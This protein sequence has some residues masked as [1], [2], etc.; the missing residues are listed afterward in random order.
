MNAQVDLTQST[1]SPPSQLTNA[2]FDILNELNSPI[3]T[4]TTNTTVLDINPANSSN[5]LSR[6]YAQSQQKQLRN[7]IKSSTYFSRRLKS[8]ITTTSVRINPL[9][10]KKHGI[11]QHHLPITHIGQPTHSN[12]NFISNMSTRSSTNRRNNLNST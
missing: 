4:T 2:A 9:I 11:V 3:V 6:N 1:E 10:L 12:P 7:F 8:S 5:T